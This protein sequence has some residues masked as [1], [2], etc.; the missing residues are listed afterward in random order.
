MSPTLF[1]SIPVPSTA[2]W[3]RGDEARWGCPAVAATTQGALSA[4]GPRFGPNIAARSL[5]GSRAR[6]SHPEKIPV[7]RRIEQEVPLYLCDCNVC[8]RI[9]AIEHLR[10]SD[11]QAAPLCVRIAA[12]WPSL[13]LRH[14]PNNL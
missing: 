8:A 7:R 1:L 3:P 12:G 13:N 11:E 2:W 5:L 4:C 9:L 14:A 6:S 10:S